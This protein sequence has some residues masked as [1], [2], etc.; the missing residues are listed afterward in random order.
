MNL[1]PVTERLAAET[2]G[3]LLIA[4]AAAFLAAGDRLTTSPAA[5]VL[6]LNEA[7]EPNRLSVG[8]VRQPFRFAFGILVA[9]KAPGSVGERHL[10]MLQ[11]LRAQVR[12]ALVGWQHPDADDV[13]TATGGRL[14]ALDTNRVLWWQDDFTL[15]HHYRS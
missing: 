2:E 12:A 14:V 1:T 7:A 10:D 5:F 8:A 11:P 6:P 4:G 9:V 13:T 3:F 15:T